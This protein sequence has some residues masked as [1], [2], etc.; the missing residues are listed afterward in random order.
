MKKSRLI[1]LLFFSLAMCGCSI[2]SQEAEEIAGESIH[3]YI[4]QSQL[5]KEDFAN[6]VVSMDG[7]KWIFD[8]HSDT[9]PK[10]LVRI[11]VDQ[12]GNV[13]VHRMIE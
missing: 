13:E 12:R 2:S 10:H 5:N 11:Y 9:V 4:V 6:P 8:Y 1:V 7:G 3:E